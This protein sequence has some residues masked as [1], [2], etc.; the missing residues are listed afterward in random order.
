MSLSGSK[1]CFRIISAR[2]ISQLLSSGPPAIPI[3]CPFMSAKRTDLRPCRHHH[4]PGRGGIGCEGEVRPVRPLPGD[5]QPVRH[6]HIDGAALQGNLGRLV[7]GKV[8]DLKID[9]LR[10]VQLVGLDRIQFPIDR[11]ELQ[12]ANPDG[13]PVRG[14]ALGEAMIGAWTEQ[15]HRHREQA[16]DEMPH[17]RVPPGFMPPASDRRLWM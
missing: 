7:A 8:D 1:P 3:L 16:G 11:A 4:A 9:T 2:S 14:E 6:D 12:D 13:G 15:Q 10:L 5:P 17:G